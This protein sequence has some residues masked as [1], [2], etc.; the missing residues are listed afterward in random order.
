MQEV[1]WKKYVEEGIILIVGKVKHSYSANKPPLR[2]WVLV[3][4]N[5]TILVAHCNCMAGLAET[6]SHVGAVLHWVETAVRVRDSTTCTSK[7]NTWLMPTPTQSIPYLQLSEIDF[8]APKRK[9][10]DLARSSAPVPVRKSIAPSQKEKDTFFREIATEQEK[11]PIILSIV[12]PYS[13]N[14]VHHRDHVPQLLYDIFKPVHLEYNYTQLLTLANDYA[15]VKVTPAMVSRLAQLTRDQSKSKLWFQYRARRITASRLRQVLHT[16]PHQPSLS[17]L[18]SICYPEIN[19]FSTQA[20]S[21]GCEHEKEALLAYKAQM[22]TNHGGF[23]ISCCG[24]VV[25]AEHPFLGASPD[26]LIQCDC[27]GQGVVEIKCPLCA[28]QMSF[29]EAADRVGTF[30]L[31]ELSEG[32]LKLKCDHSYYYQCQLQ[33]FVT[34]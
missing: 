31:S 26:A 9:K 23:E 28:N 11:K 13:Q 5:G 33:M 30:C 3:R 22:V 17:L 2:P 25:S 6:C 7:D 29:V 18:K 16:D 24:F 8:S 10:V 21:W 14:F 15:Q 4:C 34:K 27:C 12:E 32:T 20:T 19:R 1:G